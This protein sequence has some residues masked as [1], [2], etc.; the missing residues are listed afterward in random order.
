MMGRIIAWLQTP[1]GALV[2]LLWACPSIWIFYGTSIDGTFISVMTALVTVG[3]LGLALSARFKAI[4]SNR[5][6]KLADGTSTWGRIVQV[7]KL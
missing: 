1:L 6:L 4:R 5:R 3:N 2:L 7:F